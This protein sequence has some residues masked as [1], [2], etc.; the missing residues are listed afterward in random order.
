MSLGVSRVLWCLTVF[1]SIS[2]CLLVS[3][4]YC[5][6]LT[7]FQ[8]ISQCF[9]VS[10][11]YCGVLT[12]FQSISQCF[13]VSLEYCGVLTVFQSISQ[14]FVVSLEYC[15]VLT[16]FQGISQCFVVSLG[17]SILTQCHPHTTST[18]SCIRQV[19]PNG[20]LDPSPPEDE[21]N[22]IPITLKSFASNHKVN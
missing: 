4:E 11:E 20:N 18:A 22:L 8:S 13:V 2:Q 12:V 16:V 21:A 9:V 1:Q 7:V 6:V 3:L 5:G 19:R 15:G 14:C 10:L 17:V